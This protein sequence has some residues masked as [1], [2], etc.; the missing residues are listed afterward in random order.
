MPHT[1]IHVGVNS[2][3]P[4]RKILKTC[5]TKCYF[6]AVPYLD[7]VYGTFIINTNSS[8]TCTCNMSPI[9]C[10]QSFNQICESNIYNIC[11]ILTNNYYKTEHI[12]V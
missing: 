6:K 11:C 10:L 2:R 5:M 4:L 3:K 1:E 12:H 7:V 8:S 9:S